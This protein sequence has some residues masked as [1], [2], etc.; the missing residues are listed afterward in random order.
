MALA[1]RQFV[2]CFSL[3]FAV[4][5]HAIVRPIDAPEGEL[6]PDQARV[7]RIASPSAAP[8]LDARPP[9]REFQSRHGGWKAQWN[10]VTKSPHRAWGP[11]FPISGPVRDAATVDGALRSFIAGNPG[12]FG[13]PS[14]EVA[15]IYSVNGLWYARYRQKIH[16]VPVLFSDW[17]FR[18]S[19]S[20]KLMMFGADAHEPSRAPRT[21]PVL[22]RA[23]A[24]EQ[25]RRGLAYTPGK[26]TIEDGGLYLMPWS[27][28]TGVEYRL[29]YEQR[30]VTEDPPGNW[31]AFVDAEN[32]DVLFRQNR[33]RYVISGQITGAIHTLLPT[34]P[35]TT[36]PFRDLRIWVGP[37]SGV[38]SSLGN[39]SV[40]ATGTVSVR[41][42][43]IGPFCDV[44]NNLPS[45]AVFNTTV[46][47]PATVNINWTDA[48]SHVAERDAFYHVN[49]VHNFIRT[50]DPAF[51]QID[52]SM[53][54]RVNINLNCNAFW[55]GTGVNF[56]VAGSGCPNTATIPDVVYHEYGHGINDMLYIQAG[57]FGG[58]F[59]GALHEG[60]ADVN[61]AFVQDD[62]NIGKGF[63]GPGTILRTCDNTRRWPDDAGE[64]HTSGQIISG[65]FWDLRQAVGLTV[66]SRL[67]H[68]A[69]YG[70]PDDPLDDGVAMSEYFVETLIADDDDANLG[71]GTPHFS[72]IVASFNAH[73]IGTGFFV[74]FTHTPL[75][76]N[77]STGNYPVTALVRYTGPVGALDA[78]SPTLYFSVN[79]SAYVPAAMTPTG[80]PD[81]FSAVIPGQPAAIV[82]YYLTAADVYGATN[83]HPPV[84]P[85][86]E[87]FTFLAGPATTVFQQTMEANPGWTV[88]DATDN[89]T[90]GIW[91]RGNPNG[92]LVDG[93]NVQPEDDHTPFSGTVC[94]F[95]GQHPL[96]EA[97]P[98]LSDVDGGR[99]TLTSNVFDAVTAINYPVIEYYRWYTNQL[100]GA[101]SSDL[102]RTYV[103]N[104]AGASW[105]LVENTLDSK[106]AWQRVLFFIHDYVTPTNAMRLRFVASDSAA[107][108]LVEAGVDD[109]RLLTYPLSL[110]IGGDAGASRE[111]LLA[112]A[113]PNPMRS[114]ASFAFTL[115]SAGHAS[116]RVYDI[117]GRAVRT[118]H[119]GHLDAGPHLREWNGLDD[120]GRRVPSGPYFVRLEHG[121][122]Q[123][124][125][126]VVRVE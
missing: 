74:E 112:P 58:M 71:N 79:G 1:G 30:V 67:A 60:M 4:P 82:S 88:G 98:G 61:A 85:S 38:T 44:N 76:D 50:L 116:L 16:G 83:T 123:A 3:F 8:A 102:W 35:L 77:T 24:R 97:N 109:V 20:G 118:L 46:G 54:T 32:G 27:T 69:R 99:T 107:G 14:L 42:S 95:T 18:V 36:A 56:Y 124:M 63:T 94:W 87:T 10:T 6:R 117:H 80:N 89:A 111:V 55:N 119:Q 78:S 121:L 53:P 34:D 40:P 70:I 104:D 37:D 33:V 66:A 73:G 103:S 21:S 125:R 9:W 68:F 114:H 12:V 57:S 41:D 23:A 93:V 91:E 52:Y 5:A 62:P 65:A 105:A 13:T 29:V 7:V 47:N 19:E 113:S 84:A 64:A 49:L 100:G 39:Y 101:P 48:N 25:A 110:S 59:S 17:E 11:S 126:K 75:A 2:L 115:P 81:E 86:R 51:T 45:I 43:L 31:I 26:G 22:V 108:S 96:G 92:T 72:D 122:R 90:S 15:A 120:R 28:E 106:N